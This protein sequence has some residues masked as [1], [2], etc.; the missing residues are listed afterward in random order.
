MTSALQ[1]ERP[2]LIFD[3][4]CLSHFARADRLD[5][6]RGLLLP[7]NAGPRRSFSTSFAKGLPTIPRLNC[8]GRRLAKPRSTGHRLP[9]TGAEFPAFVR[10]YGLL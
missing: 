8:H 7:T 6:L 10:R 1:E 9:C 3:A 4:T 2:A 5:V